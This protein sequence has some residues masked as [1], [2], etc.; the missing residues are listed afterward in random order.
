MFTVH[1]QFDPVYHE[2]SSTLFFL[3]LY[4]CEQCIITNFSHRKRQK[5]PTESGA[6]S[7]M[8]KSDRSGSARRFSLYFI[9]FQFWLNTFLALNKTK[10][11]NSVQGHKGHWP[12]FFNIIQ[13]VC[14]SV[15]V[16]LPTHC[17]GGACTLIPSSKT[18]LKGLERCAASWSSSRAG[19]FHNTMYKNALV[20]GWSRWLSFPLS[21]TYKCRRVPQVVSIFTSIPSVSISLFNLISGTEVWILFDW[22]LRSQ[23]IH[24]LMS[25][26]V[27][28]LWI[29]KFDWQIWIYSVQ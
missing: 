20:A 19:A 11:F 1:S 7:S 15:R 23:L 16:T 4:C 29:S 2:S 24:C 26:S 13:V 25:N 8:H 12:Y 18:S 3:V 21:C 5:P 6:K 22:V 14:Q 17:W 10:T 28:V 9:I 27:P